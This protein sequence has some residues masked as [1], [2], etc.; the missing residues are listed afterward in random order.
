MQVF[1]LDDDDLH[2]LQAQVSPVPEASLGKK[3]CAG[4]IYVESG[5]VQVVKLDGNDIEEGEA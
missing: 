2:S 1:R 5:T 4:G 3:Q